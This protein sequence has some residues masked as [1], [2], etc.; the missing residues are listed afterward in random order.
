M[1]WVVLGAIFIGGVHDFT[2]LV[3]SIRHKAA[4][5]GEIVKANMSR[6]SHILFLLFVWFCLVYV[7]VA[8]TDVT[9][10]TFQTIAGGESYGP[11]VVA[12][13]VLYLL[14][15]VVMGMLLEGI[16]AVLA[17]PLSFL[18][19]VQR[20]QAWRVAWNIFGASNQL[21]AGLTLMAMALWSLVV[22]CLPFWKGLAAGGPLVVD[23]IVV[24][25]A[26]TVL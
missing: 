8:F 5:M 22:Q 2:S 26:G 14:A 25:I 6:T 7:I 17:L 16:V 23:V 24:G 9:A 15:A 21:L 12:S 4:S 10:Q 18:L 19:L 11:G 20:D 3:A 1:L 13:S